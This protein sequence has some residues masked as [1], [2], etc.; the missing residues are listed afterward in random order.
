MRLNILQWAKLIKPYKSNQIK[1]NIFE[2]NLDGLQ[3]IN[4]DISQIK[5]RVTEGQADTAT[6]PIVQ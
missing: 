2:S 4:M 6:I 5:K 1:S 3:S